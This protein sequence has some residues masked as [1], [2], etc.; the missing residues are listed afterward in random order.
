MA[1]RW[2]GAFRQVDA[3]YSRSDPSRKCTC[4]RHPRS[5]S[6]SDS[7]RYRPVRGC[8]PRVRAGI[9]RDAGP[10]SSAADR[11]LDGFHVPLRSYPAIEVGAL[12]APGS[13][14]SRE[15]RRPPGAKLPVPSREAWRDRVPKPTRHYRRRLLFAEAELPQASSSAIS[16]SPFTKAPPETPRSP[17]LSKSLLPWPIQVPRRPG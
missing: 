6:P 14:P 3:L 1:L 10:A 17:G 12:L 15:S 16:M 8:V 13:S 7:N 9:L 11:G 5:W 2:P 4:E